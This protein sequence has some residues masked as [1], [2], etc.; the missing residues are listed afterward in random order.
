MGSKIIDTRI[1]PSEVIDKFM[2]HLE[3]ENPELVEKLENHEAFT[4]S[5]VSKIIETP[6]ED[7]REDLDKNLLYIHRRK[8]FGTFYFTI[9]KAKSYL[10]RIE[11]HFNEGRIGEEKYESIKNM[12]NDFVTRKS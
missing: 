11:K 4:S 12:L 10:K 5:G 2:D 3:K 6:F 8:G 7:L 1:T 9:N